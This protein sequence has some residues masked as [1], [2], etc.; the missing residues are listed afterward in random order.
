MANQSWR[1]REERDLHAAIVDQRG[2][3]GHLPTDAP[4]T[5]P[6]R[7][8]RPSH[9]PPGFR[10]LGKNGFPGNPTLTKIQDGG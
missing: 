10:A 9:T 7:R 5:L 6:H 8:N 1:H 2:K 3:V 4:E